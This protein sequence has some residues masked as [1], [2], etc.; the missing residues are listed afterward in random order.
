MSIKIDAFKVRVLMLQNGL[1]DQQQLAR[2]AGLS[3]HTVGR[4]LKGEGFASPT[5]D[6]LAKALKCHP[7]DIIAAEGYADPHMGAPAFGLQ[8]R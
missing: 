3:N 7:I 6:K 4:V 8:K 1:K 5:L 2:S